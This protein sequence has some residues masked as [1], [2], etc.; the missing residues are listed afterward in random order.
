[1][2]KMQVMEEK[3]ERRK[4][5]ILLFSVQDSQVEKVILTALQIWQKVTDG[6]MDKDQKFTDF[7]VIDG[8]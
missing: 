1:M 3:E 4:S 7:N 2:Q 6:T 8:D 5:E